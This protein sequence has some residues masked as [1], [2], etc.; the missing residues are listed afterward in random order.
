MTGTSGDILQWLGQVVL[1]TSV[2]AV[3]WGMSAFGTHEC[4]GVLPKVDDS[5]LDLYKIENV[6][7]LLLQLEDRLGLQNIVHNRPARPRFGNSRRNDRD[8]L[9]ILSKWMGL[10]ENKVFVN[11]IGLAGKIA[12]KVDLD[13]STIYVDKSYGSKIIVPIGVICHE[14]AH[15]FMHRFRV[16]SSLDPD[17]EEL[18]DMLCVFMGLGD[19]LLVNS[20]FEEREG[21]S[22]VV[23]TTRHVGYTS[24]VELALACHLVEKV[25]YPHGYP[26]QYF[27]R[28]VRSCIRRAGHQCKS[29]G[30]DTA[31][32]PDESAHDYFSRLLDAVHAK[33]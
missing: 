24:Q 21:F 9:N 19:F 14:M 15:L 1:C 4:D 26:T 23:V 33:A 31:V 30:I 3:L 25:A 13:S 8:F 27:T 2:V 20:K 32:L 7:Y 29:M 10:E 16:H 18:T 6:L 11:F 17:E 12:G 22:P 5:R 28:H